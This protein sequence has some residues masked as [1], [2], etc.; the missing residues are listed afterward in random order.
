MSP[1]DVLQEVL[2]GECLKDRGLPSPRGTITAITLKIS[3]VT[4]GSDR[5]PVRCTCPSKDAVTTTVRHATHA[6][7][8]WAN[9]LSKASPNRSPRTRRGESTFG[10]LHVPP[11]AIG[12]MA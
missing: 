10:L 8:S 3:H 1:S 2:H 12:R 6:S 7:I 4:G 5:S 11:L 9:A